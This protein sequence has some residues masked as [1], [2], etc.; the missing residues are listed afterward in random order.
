VL[1]SGLPLRDY[2]ADIDLRPGAEGTEIHWHTVFKSKVPGMGG[3][4]RR[5]LAKATRKFVEGLAERAAAT[6]GAGPV[7]VQKP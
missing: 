6:S 1:L 4:Y 3:L 5:G 2:R 7:G